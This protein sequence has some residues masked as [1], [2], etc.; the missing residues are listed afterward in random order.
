MLINF[1]SE[2]QIE[3]TGKRE[4]DQRYKYVVQQCY[5]SSQRISPV[6]E[7]NKDIKE[8]HDHGKNGSLESAFLQ[9]I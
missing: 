4:N 5:D 7:T 2:R 9:I 6:A 3:F 1:Q 8:D